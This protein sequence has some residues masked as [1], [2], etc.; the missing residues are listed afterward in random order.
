M[1]YFNTLTQRFKNKC[2]NLF[3]FIDKDVNID[4]IG[5]GVHIDVDVAIQID[6]D[7]ERNIDVFPSKDKFFAYIQIWNKSHH[8]TYFNEGFVNLKLKVKQPN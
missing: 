5:V 8:I 3:N 6:S 4:R 7:T 1:P 2:I